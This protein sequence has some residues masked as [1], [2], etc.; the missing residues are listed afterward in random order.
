VLAPA[1]ESLFPGFL[2]LI[3]AGVGIAAA[4]L[5]GTPADRR[6]VLAYAVL[7][8]LGVWASFGPGAGL[9]AALMNVIPGIGL[10]RAPSRLGVV[11]LLALAVLAGFGVRQLVAG[12][13]W[14]AAALVPLIAAELATIPWP[15]VQADSTVPEAYRMLASKPRGPLVEFLFMYKRADFH[16]HTTYMFNSTYHW[17]PLVNG[18][19]DVIPPD[20]EEM[21]VP[22]N[23]FPDPASFALMKKLGVKYVIW[24]MTPPRGYDAGSQQE[25]LDRFPPYEKYI[26]QLTTDGGVWLYEIIG[27]P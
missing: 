1:N 9:Y 11:V 3:L 18:Y 19:S 26:R 15:L 7:A 8:L 2:T 21:A 4:A 25:I 27:Y 12:R 22:I 17:Q 10:L 20:F 13:R 6:V 24:H 14:V 23:A 5:R 16:S